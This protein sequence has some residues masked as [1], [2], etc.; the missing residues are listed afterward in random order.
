MREKKNVFRISVET[1][2]E[3]RSLGRP[4]GMK[5]DNIKLDLGVVGW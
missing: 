3:K 4:R 2:E 5:E 1:L